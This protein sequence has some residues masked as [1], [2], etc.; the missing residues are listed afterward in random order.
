MTTRIHE[1]GT[2]HVLCTVT[3]HVATI[4][5]NRP[6]K[7]N[8]IGRPEMMALGHALEA[9]EDDTDVRVVVLTG[10]GG[11]FCAGG[12]IAGMGDNL[13]KAGL[14][15]KIRGLQRAQEITTL[16]L[17]E[18]SKPTMAA[19]PGVAAG[20][21]MSLALACDL[22]IAA[23][24]ARFVPA[25]GAIGASGDFGGSWLL[26]RL[27]G[28]GRAKEIYFTGRQIEAKEAEH[29][30]LFNSVVAADALPQATAKTAGHIA[31]QAP[32]AVRYMKQNHNRAQIDDLNTSLKQE[33]D[34]MMRCLH[35]EDH[36]HA[37]EAFFA[38]RAPVFQGR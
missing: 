11:A 22:R 36:K 6:D 15:D 21:G 38:K 37:V 14:D 34:R 23:Q 31:A 29:L 24:G 28:P 25:F 10:A 20:A 9:S 1:T 17:Y 16:R 4:T 12:D 5:L 2:D 7:R 30:G 32:I 33:A 27:I 18:L 3:D 35:T 19:L 26:S 13:G 8:A